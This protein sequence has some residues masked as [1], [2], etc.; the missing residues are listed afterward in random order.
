[1]R[2]ARH[3]LLTSTT[4]RQG[5]LPSTR[6]PNAA[7][8]V[9]MEAGARDERTL[10]AVTCKRWLGGPPWEAW[11]M[12]TLMV[13]LPACK[14]REPLGNRRLVLLPQPKHRYRL[15]RTEFVQPFLV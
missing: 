9:R 7:L 10:E 3:D 15:T 12:G 2:V 4:Y 6:A 1:M 5:F 13:Q 11:F 14:T 8:Q